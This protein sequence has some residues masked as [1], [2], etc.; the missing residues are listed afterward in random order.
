MTFILT[1]EQLYDLVW[2][3]PMRLLSK[4]IG[5]SDVAIAKHCRKMEIPVPERGY[6]NKL[7]AG[8]NVTKALLP[9]RNLGTINRAEMSGTLD[10]A[11]RAKIKGEPG[12]SD[13]EDESIEVLAQRFRK[14]LGKVTVPSG[15]S[16]THPAIAKLLQKDETLR[17]NYLTSPY[18]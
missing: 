13:G 1:R 2:S 16:R 18:S 7:Q 3:E 14:R 5:I 6:W 12:I 15:F 9:D 8:K 4:Q 17:Q 10:A 11:L